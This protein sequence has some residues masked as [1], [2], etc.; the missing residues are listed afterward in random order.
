MFFGRGLARLGGSFCRTLVRFP[1]DF[2]VLCTAM[3]RKMLLAERE[4]AGLRAGGEAE[5][6]AR[7]DSEAYFAVER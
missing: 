1:T 3:S 5:F 6:A 4:G 7:T 2:G